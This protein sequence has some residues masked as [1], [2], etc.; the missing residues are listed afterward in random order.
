MVPP[1]R[2]NQAGSSIRFNPA[3]ADHHLLHIVIHELDSERLGKDLRSVVNNKR[4][5]RP[6]RPLPEPNNEQSSSLAVSLM[7]AYRN[8]EAVAKVFSDFPVIKINVSLTFFSNVLK[9]I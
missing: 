4:T 1:L 8:S 2:I 5:A 3:L 7:N 9:V 6:P